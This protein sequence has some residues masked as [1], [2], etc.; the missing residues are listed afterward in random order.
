MTR[1]LNSKAYTL[2]VSK[3]IA[4]AVNSFHSNLII[5]VMFNMY[6]IKLDGT[7]NPQKTVPEKSAC[8]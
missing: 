7:E 3:L 4:F 8:I 6:I 2:I 1:E 5:Y